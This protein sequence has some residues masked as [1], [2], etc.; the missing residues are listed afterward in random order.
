MTSQSICSRCMLAF[1]SAASMTCKVARGMDHTS[2]LAGS[3]GA[4]G[5]PGL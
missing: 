4:D 3:R 5:C 2:K 1:S